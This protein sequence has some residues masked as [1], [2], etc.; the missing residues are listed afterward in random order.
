MTF[1]LMLIKCDFLKWG[2]LYTC[3]V[4]VRSITH[5]EMQKPTEPL[6]DIGLL[7]WSWILI[8]RILLSELEEKNMRW[9]LITF[10]QCI[11]ERG[12]AIPRFRLLQFCLWPFRF[13][14]SIYMKGG[15]NVY[16][17]NPDHMTKMAVMSIYGKNPS[18]SSLES[19]DQFQ[20]NLACSIV[21]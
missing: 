18:K 16:I 5:F 4:F 1:N 12:W 20:Q 3:F 14:W 8:D 15:T 13:I 19:V 6:L 10:F 11:W 7:I 17:K 2:Y 9:P 21:N